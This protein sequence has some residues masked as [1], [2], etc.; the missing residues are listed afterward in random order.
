MDT[1]G[2]DRRLRQGHEVAARSDLHRCGRAA[3]RRVRK[4]DGSG[5]PRDELLLRE[6]HEDQIARARLEA[7]VA[8]HCLIAL[9]DGDDASAACPHGCKTLQHGLQRLVGRS[10]KN[11]NRVGPLR[12]RCG[13]RIPERQRK[14]VEL[15]TLAQTIREGGQH[16]RVRQ[17]EKPSGRHVGP[18][19]LYGIAPAKIEEHR[20]HP[21]RASPYAPLERC[22]KA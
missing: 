13:A 20:H 18:S 3:F 8:L 4:R 19:L 1:S 21:T 9:Q 7:I 16:L 14:N 6:R 17:D 12:R 2:R 10:V 5:Q 15:R 11:G 22:T